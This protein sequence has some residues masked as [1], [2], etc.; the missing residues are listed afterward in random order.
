MGGGLTNPPSGPSDFRIIKVRC[1]PAS[2]YRTIDAPT[3]S[4]SRVLL[5]QSF[6]T[7]G[8]PVGWGRLGGSV[9]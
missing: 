3:V 5:A 4:L 8:F 1:F 9:S 2:H 6:W 7:L